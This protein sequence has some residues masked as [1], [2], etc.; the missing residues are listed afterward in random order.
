MSYFTRKNGLLDTYI[1]KMP[2]NS[3]IVPVNVSYLPL[4]K[5]FQFK[6][7]FRTVLKAILDCFL[8]QNGF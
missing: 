6:M 5:I 1:V 8:L 2:R 3:W 7:A 4:L